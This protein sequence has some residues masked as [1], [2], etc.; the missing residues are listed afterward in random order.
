VNA[1]LDDQFEGLL[2]F[3]EQQ[4]GFDFRGYKRQSLA[5]RVERRLQMLGIE[6]CESYRDYLETHQEEFAQLF[7]TI[8]I[9][10]TSFFR[11][12]PAWEM[13]GTE[14]IPAIMRVKSS[15]DQVRVWSAGCSTGEEAYSLAIVFAEA[16]GDEQFR[17]RVK[18]YATDVD[19]EALTQ[20]RQASYS[21]K[22]LEAVQPDGRRRYFE[23]AND[24]FTFRPDLRR[25]VIFGRNDLVQDAPI[26]RLD[27]LVCRNTMMYF[28]AETQ[29]RILGRFH[30]ALNGDGHGNG[31]L[32]LGRAEMLLTHANLFVP[33][34]LKSRIFAKALPPGRPRAAVPLPAML[35]VNGGNMSR[36]RLAEFA[37][38]NGPV[39]RIVV[40]ANGVLVLANA[41]ARVLFSLNPR[42]LG[43]PLQE[44]E[45]SYRPLE[46]RSLIEQAYAER[47]PLTRTSVER[48]FADGDTQYLDVVISPLVENGQTPLGVGITFIDI[49]RTVA[50]QEELKR[51]H[52]QIQTANEELQSSNEELETTNEELQSSNEELETTNEELQSTNE[53][54]ETMNEELHS[55]NEELQT[56]NEE[57]RTRTE[58]LNHLNAFL[59]SILSGLS[60][61]AIVV[62]NNL[63]VLAW[64]H[65]SQDLWGL[66]AEE[67]QGKSLLNLDIGLPPAELRAVIRPC[68]SGEET[69]KEM[70]LD[71]VNRRGKKIQCRVTCTPLLAAN[72]RRDGVILL[73]EEV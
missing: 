1:P 53:E 23:P 9:N 46:L 31:Y 52:E 25:A 15:H 62:N 60:V 50:L 39:A 58:E 28:N 61:G 19:D 69:R 57:L 6:G 66:R 7:N 41:R 17:S 47:R 30:F 56:V 49:T 40:D 71:A 29:A 21:A 43:R 4:R 63:D 16:L 68:L 54:L 45:I 64:N 5:R 48:H 51:T 26:S 65:R 44:L 2:D 8:L 24:R 55:T 20:A 22:D 70:L 11:D 67:V 36:E 27:L 3:V 42:D 12:P 14:V 59:E 72:Q 18:I 13:L 38:E 32:F 73:M 10:V 34:D 33:L 35:E 37:L